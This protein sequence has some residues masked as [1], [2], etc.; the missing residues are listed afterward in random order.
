LLYTGKAEVLEVYDEVIRSP[1]TEMQVPCVIRIKKNVSSIK[2]GVKFSRINVMTRDGFR[3]QYCGSRLPMSKLNY[4]HVIPRSQG[5]KTVWENI[6]TC[7]YTCN[8]HKAGRTP[9]QAGMKLLKV[10]HRPKTLPLT[11]PNLVFPGAPEVWSF[12]LGD[13]LAAT[14]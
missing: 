10:P 4:D 5:G 14:G 6:V 11:G 3:C 2:K 7:C 12:Y 8:D 1:S 13:K 9:Q